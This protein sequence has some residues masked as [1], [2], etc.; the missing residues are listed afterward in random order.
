MDLIKLSFFSLITYLVNEY[1]LSVINYLRSQVF[2]YLFAY[3]GL[4]VV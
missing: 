4:I 3:L 2:I 1:L